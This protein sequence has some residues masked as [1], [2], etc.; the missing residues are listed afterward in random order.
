MKILLP[1]SMIFVLKCGIKS[2]VIEG[3]TKED[4][5]VNKSGHV[6][7]AAF[8]GNNWFLYDP[9]WDASFVNTGTLMNHVRSDY[10]QIAP[11]D[12]IKT[13]MPYDPLFQ[14]LNYPLSY[15]GFANGNTSSGNHTSYFNYA[16]SIVLYEKQDP[17]EQYNASMLRIESTGAPVSFT[18]TKIKQ[19][20]MEKEVIYQ[21]ND[22]DLY[23]SA[24]SDYKEA[25]ADFKTFL[26]YRNNQFLPAK[27]NE[28][29]EAMLKTVEN[30][31]AA[32]KVKLSNVDSSKATL[33]LNTG[34]VVKVLD[35]LSA[36]VTEQRAFVK[37]YFSSAGK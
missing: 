20:R 22:V 10:F 23:N 32:A 3:Y 6:W 24:V 17:L 37:N 26:N 27:S 30:K 19:L 7:C 21:D 15:K 33:V 1:S 8:I 12:F 28:E 18:D 25:F 16:D 5:F 2:F 4:G 34:D 35:D 11:S 14:F 9:T 13:H 31:I 36:H 29:I